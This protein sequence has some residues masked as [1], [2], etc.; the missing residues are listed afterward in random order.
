MRIHAALSLACLAAVP[1]CDATADCLLEDSIYE[2]ADGREFLLEFG[3]A[4]AQM[5]NVTHTATI[6]HPRRGAIFEFNFSTGTALAQAFLSLR[7]GSAEP[8]EHRAHFFD[9]DLRSATWDDSAPP[10]AFVEGLGYADYYGN[11]DKGSRD[12]VLGNPMWTLARCRTSPTD[13]GADAAQTTPT[14]VLSSAEPVA[15]GGLI[16]AYGFIRDLGAAGGQQYLRFD[17]VEWLSEDECRRRVNAG[18]L[19]WNAEDC[20]NDVRIFNE[21]D[22]A[23]NFDVSDNVE[24]AYQYPRQT[25]RTLS[26]E[27]LAGTWRARTPDTGD[28]WDG[29]WRLYRRD[30]MVERIEWVW[31]P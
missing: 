31:L 5:A 13:I 24:I 30:G 7:M 1:A 2:D 4:S 17:R 6:R 29:L 11:R 8:E 18:I 26:W 3:P 14:R 10:Y 23:V 21:D 19:N 27:A 20:D 12:V 15:D 28:L 16:A 25:P 22:E 9:K